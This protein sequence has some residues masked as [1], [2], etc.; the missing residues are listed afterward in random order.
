MQVAAA[1]GG[2]RATYETTALPPVSRAVAVAQPVTDGLH[3]LALRQI[4]TGA[5][6]GARPT[7]NR[8]DGTLN[9]TGA[10]TD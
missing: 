9:Q 7:T 1:V 3:W 4:T 10:R 6:R 2:R 5:R 8:T